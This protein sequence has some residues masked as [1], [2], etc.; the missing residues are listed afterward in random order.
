[1]WTVKSESGTLRSVMVHAAGFSHWWK[2]P[3]PGTNPLTQYPSVKQTYPYKESMEEYSQII[4]FL[5]D[6]GVK[7]FELN[8][9]LRQVLSG[10]TSTEKNEI[11]DEVWGQDKSKPKP[12]ELTVEHLVDGY[13]CYPV[14]D[15]CKDEILVA[16]KQR[17]S[18]YSRDICFMT[19]TGLVVSK[20]RTGGRR[21]QPKVAK[22]AMQRHPEL[23]KNVS[24]LFDANTI[25]EEIDFSSVA[26]EGGDVLIV[27][28]EMILCGVGQRS[29]FLG[30]KYTMES[31]FR[32]DVED[33]IRTIG[34]VRIPGPVTAGGHLDVFMNFPDERKALVMPYFLDSE[35]IQSFPRRKLLLKL[36]DALTSP[37]ALKEGGPQSLNP[38]NFRNSGACDVYRKDAA[39]RPVKVCRENNVIDFLIKEDKVDKDGFITV[40]GVPEKEND[41]AHLVRAL[42]ECLREAGNIVTIKPGLIIAYDRNSATNRNLETHGIT[43]RELLST[44]LD[45]LG[46][47]HCMTMPLERDPA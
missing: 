18:I 28:E 39:G 45:M 26:I 11:I 29:S 23:S 36:N 44:H 8:E 6:E 21:E 35:L 43:V 12:E 20:M 38:A 32:Q 42:Q 3:L 13:P 47:P 16:E 34:A 41:V 24:I 1:M 15:E 7:V 33:Q 30:L 2:I 4:G 17:G 9:T 5:R 10:A 19:Q 25:E 31:L 22:I 14:Y 40:G 27:D 46:G 37:S